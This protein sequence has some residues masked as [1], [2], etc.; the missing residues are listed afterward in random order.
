MVRKK[1]LVVDDEPDVVNFIK[2]R[3]E[4]DNFK[5]V[6]ARD[7]LAAME[8]VNKEKPDLI[9]LDIML[10]KLNGWEVCKRLK[11][12]IRH[13]YIPI[14]MVTAKDQPIDKIIGQSLGSFEYITKPFNPS[15]L[16]ETVS[17]AL[18]NSIL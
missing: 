6:I 9:L 10:P 1:I 12:H 15:E 4:A 11:R 17:K 2:T 14:V 8:M 16:M 5:V 3:L 18:S 13:K 7:G